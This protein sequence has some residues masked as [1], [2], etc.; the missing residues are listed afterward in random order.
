MRI[1]FWLG[2]TAMAM[3][4]ACGGSTP[5]SPTAPTPSGPTPPSTGSIATSVA[6]VTLRQMAGSPGA[7][8]AYEISGRVTF[9]DKGSRG[10]RLLSIDIDLMD[11]EGGVN[12]ATQSIDLTLA[13]GGTATHSLSERVSMPAGRTALRLRVTGRGVDTGGSQHTTEPGEGPVV[14]V[15]PVVT[16]PA[17]DVTVV[18]AGDIAMCDLPGAAATARLID[19][20]PGEVLALGD[21]VYPLGT[22]EAYATCYESTW[23]RHRGRTRP[24]PG[25]HDWDVGRGAPYFAY[26]GQA[27]GN[28][29]GYY[30]FDLGGWHIISLNSNN[31][32]GATSPQAAWLRADLAAHPSPCTLAFWHHPRFSSGPSG[33]TE[34]VQ[35]LWHLLDIAGVDVVLAGH[36]HM[37][38]RFALLNNEGV[39]SPTGIRSFVVGTGGAYLYGPQAVQPYS[40]ARGFAWGVLRLTLRAAGYSWAFVPVAGSSFRDEGS[41]A[42]Q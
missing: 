4:A 25:N 26:F 8:T 7:I 42:C 35:H 27:A 16:A 32:T 38:E 12:R 39:P 14:S 17:A 10:L 18:A 22:A 3:A 24:T 5:A 1:A 31:G 13:A 30:S 21:N 40:E 33:N 28:G 6:S 11:S 41:D 29:T 37:Y 15:P 2:L 23:G 20:I 9:V 36:D 34:S 19:G